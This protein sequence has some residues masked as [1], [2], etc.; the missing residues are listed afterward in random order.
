MGKKRPCSLPDPV[1]LPVGR[2]VEG[3]LD[4]GVCVCFAHTW[5][6]CVHLPLSAAVIPISIRAS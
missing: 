5:N 3:W 4:G 2:R 1:L 6:Y